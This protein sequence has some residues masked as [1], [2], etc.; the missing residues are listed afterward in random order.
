M[1][2]ARQEAP[3]QTPRFRA[4]ADLVELHVTVFDKA[5]HPVRDLK[6]TD[7]VV[8]VD[9]QPRAIANFNA[10]DVA[11]PAVSETATW[12]RQVAPDVATNA[13]PTGRVVVI[14]LDDGGLQQSDDT[15]AASM[16][17]PVV[18]AAGIE[19]MRASARAVI[20]QLGPEDL[21]A[22][23][24]TENNHTAETFTNDLQ[25]L[26]RAVEHAALIPAPTLA[27]A[28]QRLD[29]RDPNMRLQ[30]QMDA[31]GSDRSA[32]FRG[33]CACGMCSIRALERVT[34]ALRS[35]P[36][37]R[38]VIVYV[39]PGIVVN[40]TIDDSGGPSG[41]CTLQQHEGM[42]NVFRQAALANI[43]IE[44]VDP[45]GLATGQQGYDM[46][47]NPLPLTSRLRFLRTMAETTGGR[48]VVE[49]N[50]MDLKDQHCFRKATSTIS[51]ACRYPDCRLT[52]S[53]TPS[54][55]RSAARTWM[56]VRT[57]FYGAL[58]SDIAALDSSNP[59]GL[60]A[61]IG[62]ALPNAD[63]PMVLA[64]VPVLD[65]ER[66]PVVALV[67]WIRP[68]DIAKLGH[69]VELLISAFNPETGDRIASRSEKITFSR[70]GFGSERGRIRGGL[71][72]G[73]QARAVP[74]AGGVEGGRRRDGQRLLHSG[75]AELRT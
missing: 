34:R 33:S 32:L 72:P 56:C 57:G 47:G 10:V 38:K 40:T 69:A 30:M 67:V 64:T 19:R 21:A 35:L 53:S 25:R 18:D 44:A 63:V 45:K 58:A 59:T 75:R 54:V 26:L 36:H 31:V 12:V 65:L 5:R 60:N 14:V 22:V 39:S 13:A 70:T 2:S 43:T 71:Q 52:E 28:R 4:G 51:W 68:R 62:A 42:A 50:D 24:F 6:P 74:V 66:R 1:I 11:P 37:Q 29:P 23:V 49:N 7:S 73:P 27:F 20:D 46:K 8:T 61:S 3:S 41:S 48:A 15:A 17:T 9:G 16:K 55:C